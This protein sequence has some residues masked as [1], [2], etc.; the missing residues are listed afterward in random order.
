M[1]KPFVG[2]DCSGK[3]SDRA[4]LIPEEQRCVFDQSGRAQTLGALRASLQRTCCFA[5]QKLSDFGGH[6]TIPEIGVW[7]EVAS[8]SA[9]DRRMSG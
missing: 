9:K 4:S 3:R 2:K 6:E 7:R 1:M 8:S 5:W